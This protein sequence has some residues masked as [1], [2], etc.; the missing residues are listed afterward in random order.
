MLRSGSRVEMITLADSMQDVVLKKKA[1]R[2]SFKPRLKK[3]RCRRKS[4]LWKARCIVFLR[5]SSAGLCEVELL[6]LPRSSVS[7]AKM[8]R[9]SLSYSCGA[10]VRKST[11]ESVAYSFEYLVVVDAVRSLQ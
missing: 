9:S 1:D 10:L 8:A 11:G 4:R 7:L 2:L 3:G 5:H 6:E